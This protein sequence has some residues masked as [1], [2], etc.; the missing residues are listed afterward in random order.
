MLEEITAGR[1]GPID[2][3]A[4]D[5]EP[6]IAVTL[7]FAKAMEMG[8]AHENLRLLAQVIAGLKKN[9]ALTADTFMRWAGVLEQMTRDELVTIGIAYRTFKAHQN[10]PELKR[11]GF[12]C[13]F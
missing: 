1:H 4:D 5:I 9:K 8:T 7:R 2:F 13:T 6:F 12:G 3:E 10:A 11:Q